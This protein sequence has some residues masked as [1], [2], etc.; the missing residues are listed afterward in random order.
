MDGLGS[1]MSN[2]RKNRRGDGS[3][4]SPHRIARRLAAGYAPGVK[5]AP[6]T[7]IERQAEPSGAWFG[8]RFGHRGTHTSRT[9][10]LQELTD[11]IKFTPPTAGSPQYRAAIVDDNLLGKRT[12]ATRKLTAQRLS[13]LYALDPGVPIFRALRRLWDTDHAGRPLLAFLVAFAR[14]PLLRMTTDAVLPIALGRAVTTAEIDAVLEGRLGTRLN[15]S[16]RN[17]VARNAGS[18]WTQSG[19]LHGRAAKRRTKP[20]VSPGAACMALLLGYVTGLRG[21]AL[22]TSEWSRMLDASYKELSQLVQAAHRVGLLNFSQVSDVIEIQ[23]PSLIR[24]H[25]EALCRG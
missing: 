6:Q 24:P 1:T 7:T 11:V 18:T 15:P 12:L 17:K 23:F 13:E 3:S 19:H 22:F 16:V 10:M 20:V 25:E 9:M 4:S 8:L 5:T 14:D 2:P 21:R